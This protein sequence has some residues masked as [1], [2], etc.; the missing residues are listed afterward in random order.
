MAT[1][2]KKQNTKYT[3]TKMVDVACPFCDCKSNKIFERFGP[4]NYYTYVRCN[5]CSLI[6][7]N[8]RPEY[9]RS[10][11]E[12]AYEDYAEDDTFYQSGELNHHDKTALEHNNFIIQQ[13]ES[14]IGFK[15]RLLEIGCATGLFLQASKNNGWKDILGI[16]VSNKMI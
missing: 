7:L 8:P 13:I 12:T 3:P 16:D 11:V 14:K 10:F 2:L 4:Q 15:G 9:D 1:T 5:N 6:Y